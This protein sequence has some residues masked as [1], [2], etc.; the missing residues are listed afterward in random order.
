MRLRVV[1]LAFGYLFLRDDTFQIG[2]SVGTYSVKLFEIDNEAGGQQ[3]HVVFVF[4]SN[5]TVAVIGAQCVRQ[6][7]TD[8]CT[9]SF[10]LL[11]IQQ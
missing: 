10:S 8:E 4:R 11:A 1:H 7:V 9:F 5:H 2:Q 3:Q 6:Q